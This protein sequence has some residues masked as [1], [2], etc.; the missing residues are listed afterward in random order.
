MVVGGV[1]SERAFQKVSQRPPS[2]PQRSAMMALA[3]RTVQRIPDCLR[4][5][6]V[7]VLR[8]AST[9]PQ[10]RRLAQALGRRRPP[11]RSLHYFNPAVQELLD[12][13]PE[14]GYVEYLAA[15]LKPFASQKSAFP[16]ER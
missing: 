9:T 1:Y 8:P 15:K 14:P 13:P 10:D 3:P 4:R 2:S 7:M 6:P 11:V 12:H 16:G 5:W